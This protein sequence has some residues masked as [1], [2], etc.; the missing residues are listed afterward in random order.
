MF[1]KGHSTSSLMVIILPQF[2]IVQIILGLDLTSI[3]LL[4]CCNIPSEAPCPS[5]WW[6]H[7]QA[8][9]TGRP[10]LYFLGDG[11]WLALSSDCIFAQTC[12][13]CTS[14]LGSQHIGAQRQTRIIKVHT[15]SCSLFPSQVFWIVS[16][17]PL[18]FNPKLGKRR[19]FCNDF[20]QQENWENKDS[21]KK[22]K[23]EWWKVGRNYI[24]L[25]IYIKPACCD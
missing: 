25:I 2:L 11:E 18:K 23:W 22:R 12:L 8:C 19:P 15:F 17:L 4:V 3:S 1:R 14:A 10:C 24:T 13:K 21:E 16:L 5:E 6:P 7:R 9:S 20:F